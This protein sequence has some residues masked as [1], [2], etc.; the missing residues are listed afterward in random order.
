[1]GKFFSNIFK[2]IKELRKTPRGKGILF[3]A[4]YFVFFLVL[5]IMLRIT[6]SMADNED[7]TDTNIMSINSM[8]GS[9]YEYVYDIDLDE[10]NYHFL[11]KRKGNAEEFDYNGFKYTKVD[12]VY[13]L[14]DVISV[15]P[16]ESLNIVENIDSII[17]NSTPLAPTYYESG[18]VLYRYQV[19]SA[20]I[21]K[22][23]DGVDLDIDD[24]VNDI[25]VTVNNNYISN[26]ECDFNSYCLA[27]N[28]C[29]S[30]LKIKLN[31]TIMTN[32]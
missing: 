13:Y 22:I 15:R 17:T 30:G 7:G 4:F 12:N 25:I 9:Y 21:S 29:K 5:S 23:V 28:S 8:N 20:T 24:M 18:T 19:S 11:G 32:K 3:F 10:N 14:N 2:L 1:M 6:H 27:K 26:V 16:N 31:Y